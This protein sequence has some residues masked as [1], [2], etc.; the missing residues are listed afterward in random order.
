MLM[1]LPLTTAFI[2]FDEITYLFSI[3]YSLANALV[4][5]FQQ[6]AF[7]FLSLCGHVHTFLY[8]VGLLDPGM[9]TE[10]LFPKNALQH[11]NV[12]SLPA[13]VHCRFPFSHKLTNSLASPFFLFAI[14][15]GVPGNLTLLIM[16]AVEPLF[17]PLTWVTSCLSV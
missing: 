3:A 1:S 11:G 2:P 13:V 9:Y 16:N 8:G 15:V 14:W 5:F 10:V 12:P 6:Q 7:V 4:G 17:P